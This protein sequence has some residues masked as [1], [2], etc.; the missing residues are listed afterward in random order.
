MRN[1]L[2]FHRQT[3]RFLT[4]FVFLLATPAFGQVTVTAQNGRCAETTFEVVLLNSKLPLPSR[5]KL[6]VIRRGTST[7]T[8]MM[9]V[10]QGE[11]RYHTTPVRLPFGNYDISVFSDT[12][13]QVLLGKYSL[14]TSELPRVMIPGGDKRPLHVRGD[15]TVPDRGG[16]KQSLLI[17]VNPPR[18][19][20]EVH[21][22]V[23]DESRQL[24]SQYLGPPRQQWTTEPLPPGRYD[25][26]LM[27]YLAGR[28]LWVRR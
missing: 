18:E 26:W 1:A 24:I 5:V 7:K 12:S 3:T 25:V 28:C 9:A 27:A 15:Y 16:I 6:E 11:R 13:S 21:I 4:A 8:T 19:A 2:D 20:S 23:I 10:A 14:G 22:V 17:P